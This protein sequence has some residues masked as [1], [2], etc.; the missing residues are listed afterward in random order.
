LK[1]LSTLVLPRPEDILLLYV[2]AM[3]AVVSMVISVE[4]SD[5]LTEVKQQPVYFINEI[6]KDTQMWYPQVQ[7]LFYA[8]FVSD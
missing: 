3:D 5:A 7:K 4:W 1:S 2:V 8:E 6:L